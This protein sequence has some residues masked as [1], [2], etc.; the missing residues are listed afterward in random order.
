MQEGKE[1]ILSEK[2]EACV[3]FVNQIHTKYYTTSNYNVLYT[4]HIKIIILFSFIYGVILILIFIIWYTEPVQ[5]S[6]I[7]KC[8]IIEE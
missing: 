1:N 8:D 4:F 3:H 6:I 2:L 5:R 7:S